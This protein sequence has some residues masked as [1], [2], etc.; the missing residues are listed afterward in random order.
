MGDELKCT[1]VENFLDS[2]ICTSY[3]YK[4]YKKTLLQPYN[5]EINKKKSYNTNSAKTI[6]SEKEPIHGNKYV[7][8]FSENCQF[9]EICQ[10]SKTPV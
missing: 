4:R 6:K 5:F 2:N 3:S 8:Q 1:R 10:H 9:R 7:N